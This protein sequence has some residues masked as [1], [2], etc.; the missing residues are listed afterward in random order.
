[1]TGDSSARVGVP[2][3]VRGRFREER[4][5]K[6]AVHSS[7]TS[8]ACSGGTLVDNSW[9]TERTE[10]TRAF[11][12]VAAVVAATSRVCSPER[13]SAAR[14]AS[15]LCG[16]AAVGGRGAAVEAGA[17][18]GGTVRAVA[19]ADWTFSERAFAR[20]SSWAT[21][22]VRM[23]SCGA[24]GRRDSGVSR[25]RWVR[26]VLT[27]SRICGVISG[28]SKRVR[29]GWRVCADWSSMVVRALFVILLVGLTDREGDVAKWR[30]R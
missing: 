6:L 26:K 9:S 13:A 10:L 28:D 4:S 21:C 18:S 2:F 15:G 11:V 5:E 27:K 20:T 12:D 8:S 22:E 19:R 25:I 29:R 7:T 1:M 3:A 30:E 16:G 24:V 17:T 14:M 23:G